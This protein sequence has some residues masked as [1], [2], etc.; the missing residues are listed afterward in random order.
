VARSLRF[1]TAGLGSFKLGRTA[2]RLERIAGRPLKVR[3]RARYWCVSGGGSVRVIFDGRRRAVAVASTAR[4]HRAGRVA[5]GVKLSTLRRAYPK[6]RRVR[7]GMYVT[8]PGSRV[9]F[10]IRSGRVRYVAVATRKLARNARS[11]RRHLTYG[12]V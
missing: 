9:V 6:L 7:R 11:Y 4:R 12:G 3:R 8:R 1:K 5:R 2:K 10:G